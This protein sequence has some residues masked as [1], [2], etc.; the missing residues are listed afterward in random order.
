MLPAG[1]VTVLLILPLPLV[2][3]PEAPPLWVAVNVT[4]VK[5]VGKL[6]VTVAPAI[7]LG[8][9]LVTTMV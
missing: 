6:S 2:A 3:K 9:A 8:P 1:I 7:L 5:L 4:L